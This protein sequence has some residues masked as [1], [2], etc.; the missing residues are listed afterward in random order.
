M[1]ARRSSSLSW[2]WWLIGLFDVTLQYLRTYVLNHTTSR[3]DVELGARLFDHLLRL[4]LSFFETRATGQTVA[5]VRELETVRAFLTGQGLSAVIDLVFAVIAIGV[6]F[7][8]SKT[9]TLIV[10]LSIPCYLLI[11][12][13]IR[14]ALRKKINERFNRGAL[15]QQFLVESVVGIQT[16]KAAAVEPML[17][18]QWEDK[19]AAYVKTSF[20]AVMLAALGQNGIQYVS[21]ATTALVLYFGALAVING[22]LTVG[23]LIAFNM[24]MGL[25]TAPILRLS[26]LW[27][28][29]PAGSD[30][31]RAS[32][33]HPECSARDAP[34]R[35]CGAASGAGRHQ[36]LER[37]FSLWVRPA[38]GA[39][40][41]L[42]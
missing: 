22:E 25:A 16:L 3:I 42:A 17:R 2:G 19:L 28:D 5:R 29:F 11:A 21:K 8:Y 32:G 6:M 13:L 20:D 33:R 38:R 18:N 30:F 12:F 36:G 31:G 15:S 10:L 37:R 40:R 14:P 26:Q 4:P 23:A 9:L 35:L 39:E 41:R 7:I 34:A 1:A 27:Q 24:I